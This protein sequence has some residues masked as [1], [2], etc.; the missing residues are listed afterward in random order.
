L[1]N[2]EQGKWFET[3]MLKL[4]PGGKITWSFEGAYVVI[5]QSIDKTS[6]TKRSIS[7]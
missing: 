4:M 3:A 2:C 5:D 1:T 7:A 6:M